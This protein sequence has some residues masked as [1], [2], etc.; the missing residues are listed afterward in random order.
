MRLA[1]LVFVFLG[2]ACATR[3]QMTD[4]R[5]LNYARVRSLVVGSSTE[6]EVKGILGSPTG[7]VLSQGY[8]TL[9]YDDPASGAQRLSMN[10]SSE[11]NKLMD[12]LWIPQEDEREYSLDGAKGGFVGASFK[13]TREDGA[14]PHAHSVGGDIFIDQKAG[15]TIRYDSIQK[16]VEAIAIYSPNER[17]PAEEKPEAKAPYT[18]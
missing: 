18:F 13:E 1:I 7:R 16:V 4:A 10:F 15:V 2:A 6:G 14:N 5:A 11:N 3:V 9:Q 17:I 8:Y 12:I